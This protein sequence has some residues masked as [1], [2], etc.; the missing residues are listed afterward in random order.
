M[1]FVDVAPWIVLICAIL[2]L[3]F[4]A[5]KFYWVKAQ[6]E[7]S[8]K[9]SDIASKIRKGAM[10]YLKRQYKTVAVFFVIMIV[11]IACMAAGGSAYLVRSVRVSLRRFLLGT[12]RF[13][14]HEHSYL[15]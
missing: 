15:R 3:A 11:I 14:R 5:Y 10:A 2:G 12:V 1:N 13:Y 8:A 9:M 6:P 4:A 7:G